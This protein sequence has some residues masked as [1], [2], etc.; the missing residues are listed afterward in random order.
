MTKNSHKLYKI[1]RRKLRSGRKGVLRSWTSYGAACK[2]NVNKDTSVDHAT[3]KLEILP[4]NQQIVL[5]FL[6]IFKK[7]SI[8]NDVVV[9]SKD[10]WCLVNPQ[11]RSEAQS[12]C[13]RQV[14]TKPVT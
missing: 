13:S 14:Y 9:Q 6:L 5:T 2:Q 7:N 8:E 4:Q 3:G 1:K 12:M 11:L 10:H